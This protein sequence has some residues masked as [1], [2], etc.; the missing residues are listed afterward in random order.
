M[1]NT[2]EMDSVSFHFCFM[3]A[4][5]KKPGQLIGSLHESDVDVLVEGGSLSSRSSPSGSDLA[6]HTVFTGI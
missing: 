1:E 2:G 6:A 5:R 3:P 4:E